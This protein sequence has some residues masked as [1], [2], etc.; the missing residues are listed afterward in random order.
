MSRLDTDRLWMLLN[1]WS[2]GFTAGRATPEF[3]DAGVYGAEPEI[4]GLAKEIR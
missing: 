3:T 2:A 4:Q 1:G